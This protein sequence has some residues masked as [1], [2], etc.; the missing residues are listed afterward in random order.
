MMVL[1]T[2][3]G[4]ESVLETMPTRDEVQDMGRLTITDRDDENSDDDQR[5]RRRREDSA[6]LAKNW[7]GVL[8]LVGSLVMQGWGGSAW[9]FGRESKERELSEQVKRLQVE[10][11]QAR[12][13]YVRKD[14]FNAMWISINDRL[15]SID[16]KVSAVNGRAGK[17]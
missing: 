11:E 16:A 1:E 10:L 2:K 6:W 9:I 8:L 4:T 13:D 7:L 3:P 14:V 12:T 17:D 15:V 5:P